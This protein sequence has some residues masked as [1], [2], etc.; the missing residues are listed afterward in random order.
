M[1]IFAAAAT[2]AAVL[3]AS[4]AWAGDQVFVTIGTGGVTGVYYPTG[5]A[6]CKLVNRHRKEHGVRCTVESTGGSVYNVN[7]I[8]TGDLDLGVAQ[9]DVQAAA[10]NGT[11]SFEKSGPFK[12]LRAVFS[13]HPE[14]LHLMARSDSGIASFADLKGKR[15]NIGNPGSGQRATTDLLI[16]HH[17]WDKGAFSLA[18]ELKSAEQSKALCDNKLD[19]AFFT[20]GIPNASITEAS[21]L[22]DAALVPMAGDWVDAFIGK[23]PAYAKATI[24]GGIYRGNDAGVKT[25]G[26]K[27]TF[28]TSSKVSSD[29]IYHVVKSVFENFDR[30]RKQHPA[31]KTLDKAAMVKD[32][33]S[34]PLHEGAL[35][36]YREAGLIK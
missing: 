34:A 3:G 10:V 36:Y 31:F 15:V 30:F 21:T 19:A 5:G 27:A 13:I 33:L 35:R 22:C 25:F 16:A 18:A 26:P 4:A 12:E 9:S 6:I 32:G 1:K 24:P 7:A 2:V 11:R 28:V 23:Y 20:V 8:R 17:G 29:V 14:P